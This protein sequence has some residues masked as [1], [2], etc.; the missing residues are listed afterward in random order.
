[1]KRWS[2]VDLKT[3]EGTEQRF[4]L[5]PKENQ[6]MEQKEMFETTAERVSDGANAKMNS[7]LFTLRG[8]Q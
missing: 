2:S 4:G 1:M 6:P 8:S 3:V 5:R 7:S